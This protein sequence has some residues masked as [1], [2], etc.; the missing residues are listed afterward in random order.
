MKTN[1]L[2]FNATYFGPQEGYLGYS[3][4][5]GDNGGFSGMGWTH[6]QIKAIQPVLG[7]KV[8]AGLMAGKQ[9]T[10]DSVKFTEIHKIWHSMRYKKYRK[11]YVP[12]DANMEYVKTMYSAWE[13]QSPVMLEYEEGYEMYPSEEDEQDGACT[14]E[15]GRVHVV[16]IGKSTGE[17]PQML[18]LASS[19][20]LGGTTVMFSG[21][22]S[23]KAMAV[24]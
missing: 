3:F 2:T 6:D 16:T 12:R 14:S 19:R 8:Y 21:L 22:K 9:I 4:G 5:D 24:C 20:S 18:H 11:V 23:V 7:E 10:V 1:T 15:D 13:N 17:K